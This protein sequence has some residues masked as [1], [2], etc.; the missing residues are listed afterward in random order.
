M[1]PGRVASG[2][3]DAAISRIMVPPIF[4]PETKAFHLVLSRLRRE[5]LNMAIVLDEY[6]GV[7]GIVTVE[8]LIEEVV[9][10][11]YDEGEVEE[12][13]PLFLAAGGEYIIAGDAP[14]HVVN[15]QLDVNFTTEGDAQTIAGLITQELGRIPEKD[16][17][18]ETR[19]GTFTIEASGRSHIASVRFR[20]A[21]P[22][23]DE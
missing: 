20:K 11:L 23:D 8:D 12:A 16:D 3:A 2:E 17:V 1:R 5:R 7:A 21:P 18:L 14:I 4:V 10:E 6:G 9:G 15:D 22:E 13:E 19:F